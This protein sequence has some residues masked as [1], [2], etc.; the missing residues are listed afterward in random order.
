MNGTKYF[1]V[2]TALDV[3]GNESEI[4]NEVNATPADTTAPA[5]PS[6]VTATAGV[7]SVTLRW[8]ANT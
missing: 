2:I 6:G 3:V 1:Y 5:V 7:Q 8:N 4:S